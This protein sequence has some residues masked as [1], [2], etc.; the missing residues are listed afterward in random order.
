MVE[1]LR[2]FRDSSF[3]LHGFLQRADRRVRGDLEGEEV[4]IFVRGSGNVE[5]D[6][7]SKIRQSSQLKGGAKVCTNMMPK[8]R[9]LEVNGGW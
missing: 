8:M 5:R 4:G 1:V 6:A 9:S 7:P 3:G 2:G